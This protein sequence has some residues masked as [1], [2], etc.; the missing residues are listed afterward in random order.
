[1]PLSEKLPDDQ[2]SAP[3]LINKLDE[4]GEDIQMEPSEYRNEFES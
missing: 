4:E 3:S 1:M 2:I